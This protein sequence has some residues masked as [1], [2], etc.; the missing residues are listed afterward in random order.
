MPLKQLWALLHGAPHPPQLE[1]S[2]LKLVQ[3]LPHRFGLLAG[4][5]QPP[6]EHVFPLAVQS[7]QPAAEPQLWESLE[8][9]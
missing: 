3:V 6:A 9:S 7:R 8:L 4:Q 2:V 1:L 5:I